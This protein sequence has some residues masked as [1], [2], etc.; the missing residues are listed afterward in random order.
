M[1]IEKYIGVNKCIH[2]N[3]NDI[4]E[5][6]AIKIN[7]DSREI[8]TLCIVKDNGLG[9]PAYYMLIGGIT[10]AHW[11]EQPFYTSSGY[12]VMGNENFKLLSFDATFP[13]SQGASSI[14]ILNGIDA[15]KIISMTVNGMWASGGAFMSNQFRWVNSYEYDWY[16]GN[17][18]NPPLFLTL[19]NTNSLSMVNMPCKVAV[20][21]KQ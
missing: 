12:L 11:V 17:G 18:I 2:Y 6:N 10:N 15:S 1:S 5:R 8:G 16:T 4:V 7:A 3:V 21:V 19:S 13:S 20:W 14:T 9:S